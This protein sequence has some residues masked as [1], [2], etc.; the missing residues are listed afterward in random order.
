MRDWDG[1]SEGGRQNG[2]D[3]LALIYKVLFEICKH[4]LTESETLSL[5]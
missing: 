2:T 4:D 5:Y 1:L 3:N